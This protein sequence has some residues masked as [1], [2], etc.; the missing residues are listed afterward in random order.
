MTLDYSERQT[1]WWEETDPRRAAGL[2]LS[3]ADLLYMQAQSRRQVN[4]RNA[5]LFANQDLSSIYD[6]G[7]GNYE[8]AGVYLSVNV[9]ESCIQTLAAKMTRSRVRPV[10]LTEKGSRSLQQQAEAGTDFMDG[11]GVANELHETEGQQMFVDGALFGNG[12]AYTEASTDDEERPI[13]VERVLP[14]EMLFDETEAMYGLRFLYTLYR[15]KYIHRQRLY[16]MLDENGK[17]FADDKEVREAIKRAPAVQAAGSMWADQGGQMVPVTFGWRLPTKKG[18]GDGRMLVAIGGQST[19]DG[20]LLSTGVGDGM[21]L[22]AKEWRRTRFPFDCFTYQRRPV[23]LFG[24]SL[25]EMLVPIQLKINEQL[26]VIDEGQRLLAM[27]RVFYKQGA[28]NTD[29]F[30]NEVARFIEM[31]AGFDPRTDVFVDPGK[32]AAP[33]MYEDLERWIKRA[34][35]VTGVSQLSATAEKPEGISS[36]VALRE[37][38]DR[39]DMRFSDLGQRWEAFNRRRGA[40][41]LDTA[42]EAVAEGKRIIVTLPG[43]RH[44]KQIDF[45]ELGLER[46]K[47]VVDVSAASSLPTT[48]AARKQ[49]ANEL[50]DRQAISMSRYL[51]I[52]D[53]SG[54]VE[55]VTSL[56]TAV[57]ESIDLD[58]DGILDKAKWRAP[59]KLRDPA[60][61]R[62]TALARYAQSVHMDVPAKNLELL[63]R[64]IILATKYALQATPPPAGIPMPLPSGAAAPTT[65]QAMLPIDQAAAAAGAPPGG[66]PVPGPPGAMPPDLA[67][68]APMP[69]QP[70]APA[71]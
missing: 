4:L 67:A 58:I 45:K 28:I 11:I 30:D 37:L 24:R 2:M 20:L 39:E 51:E 21:K 3:V 25:A 35:E 60:L 43:D 64:Y 62:D 34:Y 65:G 63:R 69:V 8:G 49:Y 5:K 19:V 66:P 6:C 41:T 54:D 27:A 12:W 56:V 32:G 33:E 44:A 61:A 59:E 23:G 46:R 10:L 29:N 52:I 57:Q 71:G 16:R 26:E 36:A 7:V 48:P 55:G 9:V 38:L 68:Q 18:A 31:A 14:D 53:E 47:M 15:R 17:P 40:T 70:V 1:L 13:T 42:E 50:L 22:Y